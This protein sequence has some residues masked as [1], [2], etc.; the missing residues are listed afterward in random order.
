MILRTLALVEMRIPPR[1]IGS[2]PA[3]AEEDGSDAERG[4]TENASSTSSVTQINP[5]LNANSEFNQGIHAGRNL[6]GENLILYL[7][8]E[9][10]QKTSEQAGSFQPLEAARVRNSI[11]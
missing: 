7:C 3:P 9:T 1:C 8:A 2:A 6:P 5:S 10:L 4:A 11:E